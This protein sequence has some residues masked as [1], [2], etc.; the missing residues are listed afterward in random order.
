MLMSVQVSR[1]LVA[2]LSAECAHQP[3]LLVLE[4][5][6]WSDALTVKLPG[7]W[8][9]RLQGLPLTGL[10]RKAGA[11]LVREVLGSQVPEA[12]VQRTVEMA[13]GN[14]LF[15]EEL[16]RMVADGRGEAIPETVLAVLQARLMRM[17]AGARQ[18]LPQA[19][20]RLFEQYDLQGALWCTQ[21][22]LGCGVE[23]RLRTVPSLPAL[24]R[25]GLR[26]LPARAGAGGGG[27]AGGESR[28]GSTGADGR[29]GSP[30]GAHVPGAGGSLLRAGG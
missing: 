4:D 19:A 11:R 2:F 22:A 25:E 24:R 10:S 1:A 6:H 20:T 15:L 18:V 3:V 23:E 26:H 9:R 14:A 13:D 8:S 7:L 29:L 5:L 16:I 30:C 28:S 17:E 12:V 27:P 21:E